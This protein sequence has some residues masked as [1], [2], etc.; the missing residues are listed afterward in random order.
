MGGDGKTLALGLQLL[1]GNRFRSA[2]IESLAHSIKAED[3][4]RL[5]DTQNGTQLRDILGEE[6]DLDTVAVTPDSRFVAA[7]GSGRSASIWDTATGQ[8]ITTIPADAPLT[9]IA[10]APDGKRMALGARDGSLVLFSLSG[11][12]PAL[13]PTAPSQIIIIIIEPSGLADAGSAHRGEV[14]KVRSTTLRLRGQIKSAAPLKSLL[15]DGNEITSLQPDGSGN[16]LFNAYVPIAQPGQRRFEVVAE[17]VEGTVSR[18]TF[19]V[20]R[21]ADASPPPLGTG[22]RI[23]LIVGISRYADPSIDLEYAAEDASALYQKLT[24]PALG[25]AAFQPDD[26]MLLLD[27][28]ATTAA[29]TTGL[30]EFLQKA[31]ENDFVLFFFAGHG[32]PDPNRLKDLYLLAHDTDPKNIAG[33]GLLMRH[34][35]EAIAEIPARDVLILSDA[36]HSGGIG[37]SDGMRA[38]TENPIHQV[39]LEK[40]RHSSGGM[41]ILTAS[42]A[43]Q[44]SFENAKWEQHGVFTYFLLKGLRGE[45]DE[46]HDGIVSLGEILEYV[47][48]RVRSATNSQQIPAIGTTSFDRQ[49]PLA[50]VASPPPTK[51]N[52]SHPDGR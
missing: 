18:Q 14:P 26:V 49:M 51:R 5:V 42:E 13:R 31:R 37:A 29:I 43:A 4:L 28:K 52:N 36:C 11:V 38:V 7:G 3:T 6:Q 41:A 12:G 25:P 50:I 45:A 20:E 32:A 9:A 39:F 33:T 22:R 23:A 46:D 1:T 48:D 10:F 8:R 47:R 40:L 16:Y 2:P 35:R 30:R 17:N 27:G 24:D 19:A 15:V 44:L 21:T 34:V